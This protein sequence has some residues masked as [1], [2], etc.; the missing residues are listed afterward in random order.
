MALA[1][2]LLSVTTVRADKVPKSCTTPF[3][4][5]SRRIASPEMPLPFGSRTVITMEDCEPPSWLMLSGVARM[6]IDCASSDG[7]I[8]GGASGFPSVQAAQS[9]SVA[10]TAPRMPE[11]LPMV[12]L[13]P[14]VS[15]F[16]GDRTRHTHVVSDAVPAIESHVSDH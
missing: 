15:E 13:S 5:M 4:C 9:A 10:A 16:D 1:T 7:P 8:S 14:E 11:T 12:T 2:P 3:T 6:D